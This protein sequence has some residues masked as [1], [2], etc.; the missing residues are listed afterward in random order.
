MTA[1]VVLDAKAD[2]AVTDAAAAD[3]DEETETDRGD[4]AEEDDG[5]ANKVEAVD[6]AVSA[7]TEVVML[8]G[9]R[10]GA[11]AADGVPDEKPIAKVDDEEAVIATG[12]DEKVP[13]DEAAVK[14]LC[15]K[16]PLVPKEGDEKVQE[17]DDDEERGDAKEG[18][19]NNDESDGVVVAVSAI[20][21]VVGAEDEAEEAR[22]GA[23]LAAEVAA[24]GVKTGETVENEGAV[25]KE[26]EGEDEVVSNGKE[27]EEDVPNPN[28]EDDAPESE[29]EPKLG[30]GVEEGAAVEKDE[31]DVN[32]EAEVPKPEAKRGEDEGA[33]DA[34][35]EAA[36]AVGREKEKRLGAEAAVDAEKR[37][38]VVAADETDE[39]PRFE[40]PNGDGEDAEEE[41][42]GKEEPAE[43]DEAASKPEEEE[44][45]GGFA[46]CRSTQTKQGAV[47]SNSLRGYEPSKWR[48][49]PQ[50]A[51]EDSPSLSFPKR[52]IQWAANTGWF[53]F[54]WIYVEASPN[55]MYVCMDACMRRTTDGVRK[56]LAH[57]E[58]E[59]NAGIGKRRTIFRSISSCYKRREERRKNL[60]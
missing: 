36:D 5:E 39:A 43:G 58:W 35:D 3:N 40:K 42:V 47:F 9:A 13:A 59:W 55:Y 52:S 38:A 56:L 41:G 57:L 51:E 44:A 33:V 2:D 18:E 25:V 27:T 26:E 24:E 14:E 7:S 32:D 1:A 20:P 28:R 17:E 4:A 60:Y 10:D 6:G 8:V 34:E 37:S 45:M 12:A 48:E 29:P 50:R 21:A 23:V 15:G 11:A 31:K 19:G 54:P 30:F 53:E 16:D 49:R 22:E 46:F